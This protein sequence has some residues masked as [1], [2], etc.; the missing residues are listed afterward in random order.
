MIQ[1]QMIKS[2]GVIRISYHYVNGGLRPL[3]VF[4]GSIE[5]LD[6]TR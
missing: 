5:K 6:L 4:L 3:S 2:W 1:E